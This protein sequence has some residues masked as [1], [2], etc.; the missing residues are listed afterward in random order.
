MCRGLN[1]TNLYVDLLFAPPFDRTCVLVLV[2]PVV[3][4]SVHFVV[5]ES[6]VERI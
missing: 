4:D 3:D 6:M 5:G 1:N 2:E